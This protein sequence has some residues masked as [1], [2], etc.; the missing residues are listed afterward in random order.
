[1]KFKKLF[2]IVIM[3]MFILSLSAC[4]RT[5]KVKH[6]EAFVI[7]TSE[8]NDEGYFETSGYKKVNSVTV[9]EEGEKHIRTEIRMIEDIFDIEGNYMKT[10]AI[11]SKAYQSNLSFTDEGFEH[12]EELV[13]PSTILIP[14]EKW[15]RFKMQDLTEEQQSAVE[16]H[17]RALTE[18]MK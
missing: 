15:E 2:T 6:I 16:E 1:M 10:E 13:K 7:E 18:G 14:D 9:I 11:Y 17:V 8:K 3:A 5:E 4:G 12:R